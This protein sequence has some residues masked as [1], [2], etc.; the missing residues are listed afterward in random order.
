[1][2]MMPA[3]TGIELYQQVTASHPRLGSRFVFLTGG[4]TT[5][6][7]HEFLQA[8]GRKMVEK[9]FAIDQLRSI[10]GDASRR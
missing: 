10:V 1:D 8:P 5:D 3:M 4:A 7:A 2:L 6:A 9:P